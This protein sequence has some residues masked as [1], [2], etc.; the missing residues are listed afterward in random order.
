MSSGLDGASSLPWTTDIAF[1]ADECTLRVRLRND[2]DTALWGDV[3]YGWQVDAD[4]MESFIRVLAEAPFEAYFFET[5]PVSRDTLDGNF[6][7]VLVDCPSLAQADPEPRVF[8][9]HF[10]GPG[11]ADGIATFPN[12]GGDAVL[13][14]PHPSKPLKNYAHLAAFTRHAPHEQQLALWRAVSEAA[15]EWFRSSDPVWI[16]T[17]GLEVFWLHVRLDHYP[18]Y[19]N[20]AAYRRWSPG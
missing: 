1:S 13:I 3:I 15:R 11:A 14:A 5:P 19:Y 12:L 2:G 20:H 6:E 18:K 7:F 4:M 17:S 10:C 8:E 16:S 9:E